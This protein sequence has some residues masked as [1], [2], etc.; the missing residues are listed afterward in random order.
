MGAFD[1]DENWSKFEN[2]PDVSKLLHRKHSY[3][4]DDVFLRDIQY[5]FFFFNHYVP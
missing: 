4:G 1:D 5:H 3:V 2:K